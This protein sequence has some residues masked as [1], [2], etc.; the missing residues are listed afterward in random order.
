MPLSPGWY[1]RIEAYGFATPRSLRR[2]PRQTPVESRQHP[3]KC[4][5]VGVAFAP[6]GSLARTVGESR[7]VSIGGMF[8]ETDRPAAFGSEIDLTLDLPGIRNPATVV[9][10]VRWVSPEGMGVQFGAM[11][12][13]ETYGITEL[14]K[15]AG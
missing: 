15:T 14:L 11:G 2:R 10:T 9:A 6:R 1:T 13:R 5:R 7:D 4:V 8:I 12:A 3:R